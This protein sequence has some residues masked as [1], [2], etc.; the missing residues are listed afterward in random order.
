MPSDKDNLIFYRDW[1]DMIKTLPA[2]QQAAI[3]NAVME[4]AFTGREPDDQLISLVTNLMRRQIDRDRE[5]YD[6][7]CESRRA[8]GAKGGRPRQSAETDTDTEKPKKAIGFS[9]TEKTEEKQN[10]PTKAKKADNDN[11]YDNDYDTDN[12]NEDFSNEKSL[13][14]CAESVS[15]SAPEKV[16]KF[17]ERKFAEYYNSTLDAARSA[18][19]RL[20]SMTKRRRRMLTGMIALYGRDAVAE[21]VE[22]AARSKFLNGG[23]RGDFVAGFDWLFASDNFLR[24]LEGEFDGKRTQTAAPSGPSLDETA[25]AEAEAAQLQADR[26]RYAARV[27]GAFTARAL[28]SWPEYCMRG[29]EQLSDDELAAEIEKIREKKS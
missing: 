17:D 24:V 12:D 14:L 16:E 10:N 2:E 26:A 18:I 29:F 9:E 15:E 27:P 6:R 23:G 5:R 25:A 11:E 22:K 13:T 7:R 3:Y 4:Y 8:N 20:R 21:V 19:P 28:I 1:W